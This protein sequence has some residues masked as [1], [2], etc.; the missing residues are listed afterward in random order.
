MTTERGLNRLIAHLRAQ[1]S[2][3][4]RLEVDGARSEEV[5]ERRRVVRRLKSH[6]AAAVI[7]SLGPA[8]RPQLR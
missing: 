6:L 1:V 8:R 7:D 5:E 3:L 4:R 2:E